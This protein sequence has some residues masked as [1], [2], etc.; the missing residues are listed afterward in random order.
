MDEFSL[1]AISRP[2]P[3]IKKAESVNPENTKKTEDIKKGAKAFESYFV[4]SL[5]K[6]MRKGIKKEG[7]TGY[8]EGMYQSMFDEAIAK[9]IAERG[10]FGLAE[11]L[12]ENL[13]GK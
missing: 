4:Q 7:G 10:G 12:I 3:E 13:S 6:E 8:G 2:G 11:V 5:L 9:N 1:L